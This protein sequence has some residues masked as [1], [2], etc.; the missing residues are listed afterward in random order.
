MKIK[1]R[2]QLRKSAKNQ[3]LSDITSV[4]GDD[5]KQ[6]ENSKFETANIDDLSLILVDGEPLLFQINEF[7]FPT[8]RGVLKLGLMKNV[9]TVDS[10]AVRFV[11]NGA[12]IMCPGIVAADDNIQEGDPV[13]IIEEAHSKPLAIGTA[14]IPGAEMKGNTGKGVK[15]I[16]YVG[17]KLWNLDI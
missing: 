2:V 10:G 4:F 16:H 5:V 3:L 13:I 15:S 11:V 9:V 12:D 14:L 7:Y 17:D 8:V 6:L 1:S